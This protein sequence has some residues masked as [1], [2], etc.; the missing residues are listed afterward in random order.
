ML[1]EKWFKDTY[2]MVSSRAGLES[3]LPMATPPL[4]RR[5]GP[6][7]PVLVISCQ[8]YFMPMSITSRSKPSE[9]SERLSRGSLA[10]KIIVVVGSSRCSSTNANIVWPVD[11]GRRITPSGCHV[12]RVKLFAEMVKLRKVRACD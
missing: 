4:S 10:V 5:R 2:A 9:F 1:P 7:I 11:D 8:H 12:N 3:I 6:L